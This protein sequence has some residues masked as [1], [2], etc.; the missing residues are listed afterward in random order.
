MSLSD[1]ARPT[2]KL[3]ALQCAIPLVLLLGFAPALWAED[4]VAPESLTTRLKNHPTADDYTELGVWFAKSE[5]YDCAVPAFAASLNLDRDSPDVT[6]MFGASLLMSGN[7]EDAVPPLQVAE[8]A[9]PNNIKVHSLLASAFEQLNQASNAEEEW[10][11]V[12]RI[13]PASSSALDH[14]STRLLAGHDYSGAITLLGDPMIRGERTAKQS[15]NLG[16][17]YAA[18]GNLNEAVAVLRDG[19]NTSPD[20]LPTANALADVLLSL[21]RPDE[22]ITVLDLAM[23]LHPEDLDTQLH[24]RRVV[25]CCAT[26]RK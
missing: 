18:S 19:L 6:L 13:D 12:L 1:R 2:R 24:Y 11:A 5:K 3:I 9:Q 7:A 4:C 22:A 16:L 14:L 17:A 8:Q 21:E 10:R 15:L 25:S 26:A 23:V 20:S